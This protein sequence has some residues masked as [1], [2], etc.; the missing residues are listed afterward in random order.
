MKNFKISDLSPEQLY[1]IAKHYCDNI[2]NF[3]DQSAIVEYILGKDDQNA[4]FC[5]WDVENDTPTGTITICGLQYELTEE[6]RGEK[7]EF[8]QYLFDKYE[9][10]YQ[11]LNDSLNPDLTN[12]G[13]LYTLIDKIG[14]KKDDIESIVTDLEDLECEDYPEVMQWFSANP[15]TINK[16]KEVGEVVISDDYWGRTCCGQG[17]ECDGDIQ[18]IAF[19]HACDYGTD[20]VSEETLTRLGAL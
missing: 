2:A 18:Q 16:L 10:F 1:T 20:T 14:D 9:N 6:Q 19:D 7:L 11:H 17:I 4:P 15:Y 3:N 12:F 13:R 8:Y 5:R